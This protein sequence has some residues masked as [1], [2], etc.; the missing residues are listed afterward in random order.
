MLFIELA[1][2]KYVLKKKSCLNTHTYTRA[3]SNVSLDQNECE[4]IDAFILY[5]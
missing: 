2:K 5:N 4:R 1:K 3:R